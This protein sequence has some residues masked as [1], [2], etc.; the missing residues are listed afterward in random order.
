LTFGKK[1]KNL[2]ILILALAII[3][4]A[5]NRVSSVPKT[6]HIHNATKFVG[7]DAFCLVHDRKMRLAPEILGPGIADIP[8]NFM[9]RHWKNFPNDGYFY[10]VCTSAMSDKV[11]VC[12]NCSK[13]SA[14]IKKE[15]DIP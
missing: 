10:P 9:D 6:V 14:Q 13:E 8:S 4:C 3:S 1:M 15:M 12:P 7:S 5:S 11:W 2:L